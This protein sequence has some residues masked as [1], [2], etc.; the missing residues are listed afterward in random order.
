MSG[1]E[2]RIPEG[3]A[4]TVATDTARKT[5]GFWMVKKVRYINK[6]FSNTLAYRVRQ[7]TVHWSREL[8]WQG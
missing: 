4:A 3:T 6:H 8:N 1:E 7:F 5:S 2:R